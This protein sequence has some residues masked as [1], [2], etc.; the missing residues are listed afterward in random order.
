M[1]ISERIAVAKPVV[2]GGVV[3]AVAALT[4][5]FSANL[6]VSTST[7]DEN[8]AQARIEAFA[9]LCEQNARAHW[10]S[11]GKELAALD[12]WRNDEREALADEFA[13][14]LTSDASLNKGIADRCDDLLQPA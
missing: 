4:V 7:M 13:K 2:I 11:Q 12:G 1:N 9:Q 10:Q 5:G 14:G 6:L 3:G 8:V